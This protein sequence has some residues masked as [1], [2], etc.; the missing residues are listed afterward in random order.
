M[1][2]H[3]TLYFNRREPTSESNAVTRRGGKP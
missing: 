2:F 1:E 3:Q